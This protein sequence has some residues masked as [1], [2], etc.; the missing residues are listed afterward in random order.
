MKRLNRLLLTL[1]IVS[2]TFAN[3]SRSTTLSTTPVKSLTF[4]DTLAGKWLHTSTLLNSYDSPE[5][6][7]TDTLVVYAKDFKFDYITEKYICNNKIQVKHTD[8]TLVLLKPS[9]KI[10]T[11][12]QPI[13]IYT[14]ETGSIIQVIPWFQG[15]WIQTYIRL[16][17]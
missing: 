16:E 1:V 9:P 12:Y 6:Q 15:K 17:K 14:L 8:S 11:T 10:P 7:L 3:C 2:L 4:R 13:I 5:L